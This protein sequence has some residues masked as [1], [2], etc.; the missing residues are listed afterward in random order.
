MSNTKTLPRPGSTEEIT[1][2]VGLLR[3]LSSLVS[4]LYTWFYTVS[5]LLFQGAFHNIF[6]CFFVAYEW[7]VFTS[8]AIFLLASW[9]CGTPSI[10]F[11]NKQY[12]YH[13]EMGFCRA[14]NWWQGMA[15]SYQTELYNTGLINE[16][17]TSQVRAFQAPPHRRMSYILQVVTV[18]RAPI[19]TTKPLGRPV[20]VNP[21]W[22][23]ASY[24]DYQ[25]YGPQ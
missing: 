17:R 18:P 22:D 20:Q 9:G 4:I 6:C 25:F 10:T 23:P 21:A 16:A 8:R 5:W 1:S 3:N 13:N 2:L 12:K 7:H 24:V 15:A 14:C 19:C 11:R